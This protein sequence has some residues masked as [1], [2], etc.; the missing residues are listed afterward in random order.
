MNL[1]F[2]KR[3]GLKVLL[4]EFSDGFVD[5]CNFILESGIKWQT[6]LIVVLVDHLLHTFRRCARPQESLE[7]GQS[8]VLLEGYFLLV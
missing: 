1:F 6:M 2:S 3:L 5:L 8:L 4:F 7:V